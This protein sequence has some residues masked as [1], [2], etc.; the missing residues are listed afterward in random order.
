MDRHRARL[1]KSKAQDRQGEPCKDK[2]IKRGKKPGHPKCRNL[3]PV[4]RPSW[5]PREHRN[6]ASEIQDSAERQF[7][8]QPRTTRRH[9]N[10]FKRWI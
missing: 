6:R 5:K 3:R 2:A 4:L 9:F 1:G 8:I 10:V 7:F